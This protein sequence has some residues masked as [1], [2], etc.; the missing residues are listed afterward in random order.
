MLRSYEGKG[1]VSAL[2]AFEHT[3]SLQTTKSWCSEDTYAMQPQRHTA[4]VENDQGLTC[5]CRQL[6]RGASRPVL[7]RC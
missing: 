7:L 2:Q 3:A 4:P 6:R 1:A 5:K